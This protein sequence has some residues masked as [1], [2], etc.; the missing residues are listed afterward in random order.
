[1]RGTGSARSGFTVVEL[2]VV[3]A[4]VTLALGIAA[5]LMMEARRRVVLEERRIL[6]PPVAIAL[7]QL[8]ADAA[9]A[10][11]GSGR[12]DRGEPLTLVR[13][14]GMSVTYELVGRD[15]MR[16]VSD[17]AG[18]RPVL[19]D[20]R[21]FG[22]TWQGGGKPLLVIELEYE[23]IRLP[24]PEVEEGRRVFAPRGVERQALAVTL[25]GGGGEGW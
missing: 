20:V 19:S 22:W 13:P 5:S 18:R 23:R 12:S 15:L 2:S 9:A 16:R 7:S 4:I 1:M 14:S 21:R 8:R 17:P 25:R 3:L 6:E 24:G 11:G 10:S